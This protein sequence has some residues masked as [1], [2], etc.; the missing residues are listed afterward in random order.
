MP[1]KSWQKFLKAKSRKLI[2]SFFVF[3]F[4]MS[5]FVGVLH[6]QWDN[7]LHALALTSVS[8][9]SG[10]TTLDTGSNLTSSL[11]GLGTD[12]ASYRWS[13]GGSPISI[14][15]APF[16][17]GVTQ[18]DIT[19]NSN[20]LTSG[21]VTVQTSGCQVGS[22]VEFNGT[23]D[24][25]SRD[26]PAVIEVPEVTYEAWINYDGITG[27]TSNMIMSA[28]PRGANALALGFQIVLL[29]DGRFATV[30]GDGSGSFKTAISSTTLST[31]TWYHVV[32]TFDGE[33]I[34]AYVNGV[35]DGSTPLSTPI[36]YTDMAPGNYPDPAQLF[37]G[38]YRTNAAG[39]SGFN[40]DL[41]YFDGKIDEAKIYN[42]ALSANQ[43]LQNYN[44]GLA[45]R[46]AFS[47]L[48][49]DE[50]LI[51]EVWN[52]SV[53][54]VTSAGSIGSAVTSGNTATITS[55]TIT[56]QIN[57]GTTTLSTYSDVSS[58][59]SGVGALE[60]A[61]NWTIG[62]TAYNQVYLP[63]IAG[64]AADFSGNSNNGTLN[65]SASVTSS[66]SEGCV[67]GEC[68]SL[69]T[70]SDFVSLPTLVG[71]NY[72]YMS[73]AFWLYPRDIASGGG[74]FEYGDAA[75]GS[76][77]VAMGL[78]GGGTPVIQ[79]R[80]DAVPN[81]ITVTSPD[82]IT[83]DQWH[84]LAFSYDGV[85]RL[86]VNGVEKG[87][88]YDGGGCIV[89]DSPNNSFVVGKYDL[90]V[91]N[92][93]D[94]LID[95]FHLSENKLT[96]AQALRLYNDG[97]AN[98]AGPTQIADDQTLISELW[99]LDIT[100]FDS[101]GSSLSQVNSSNTTTIIDPAVTAALNSGTTTLSS[102]S[103]LPS[104]IV[105]IGTPQAAYSW[106]VGVNR[107]SELNLPFNLGATQN[108]YSGNSNNGTLSN[109]AFYNPPGGVCLVGGCLELDGVDDV[110]TGGTTNFP[111]GA[112]DR[113]ISLWVKSDD[114]ATGNIM[115]FGYGTAV[116]DGMSALV[117]GLNN[118]TDRNF[119]FWGYF[120]DLNSG[121]GVLNNGAW[122]HLA[123]TIID[124][125]VTLYHDGTAI[126][127]QNFPSLN[128][129][130]GSTYY[131]GDF[132]STMGNFDGLIDEVQV[133]DRGFSA[134]QITQIYN[135]GNSNIAGPSQ[136]VD[137][138]TVSAEVWNVDITPFESDGTALSQVNSSNTVTITAPVVTIGLNNSINFLDSASN[139][140]SQVT[141]LG[142]PT[143]AYNWQVD[144]NF[145][146]E[147]S[148]PFNSG[149]TQTDYSGNS[150][151]GTSTNGPV[152]VS[153]GLGVCA[154]GGCLRFDGDDD[155]VD[156]SSTSIL[157]TAAGSISAWVRP[158]NLTTTQQLVVGRST[159]VGTGNTMLI[160]NSGGNASLQMYDGS[161]HY[162]STS[163]TISAGTWYHLVATWGASGMKIYHN[164]VEEG[165]N[166]FTGKSNSSAFTTVI[167]NWKEQVAG[168]Y[169]F[170]GYIDE[171]Q[172]FDIALSQA[173]ITQLYNDGNSGV[174]GPTQIVSAET[175]LTEVWDLDITPFESNG[176][177]L[178]QS[179]SANTVTIVNN[180]APNIPSL[181]DPADTSTVTVLSPTLS[182][183]FSDSGTGLGSTGTTEYRVSSG[184]SADC[185]NNV[186]IVDSGSSASTSSNNEDT[187]RVVGT[188]LTDLTTYN[189][190][191]RNFDQLLYSNSGVYT[192]MGSFTVDVNFVPGGSIRRQ[193]QAVNDQVQT[194][195][196]EAEVILEDQ[197]EEE[198]EDIFPIDEEDST[199]EID[200]VQ[201]EEELIE[202]QPE[203]EE[204]PTEESPIPEQEVDEAP[205]D[206]APPPPLPEPTEQESSQIEDLV[207]ELIQIEDEQSPVSTPSQPTEAP[208]EVGLE[209]RSQ[210]DGRSFT[211]EVEDIVLEESLVVTGLASTDQDR[212]EFSGETSLPN[213]TVTLIFDDS[214]FVVVTSDENGF[215][216]AFVSAQELGVS[217]GQSA[218]VSVE[219]IAVKDNLRSDKVSV[220][221]TEISLT[222]DEE[223][224]ADFDSDLVDSGVIVIAERVQEAIA[225]FIVEEEETIQRSLAVAT[226]VVVASSAPLWGYAP[227]LPTLSYQ[228]FLWIFGVL[229]KRRKEGR[230]YGIAYDSITKQ[231]LALAIVRI[232][233][234]NDGKRKLVTTVVTDKSGRYEALLQSGEYQIE[235]I[236][237]EYSFP[238]SLVSGAIDGEFQ[239]I[240]HG[241]LSM[242]DSSM[243]L[244]D[245]PLDPRNAN[246]NWE[247]ASF[248]KKLVLG[249][250]K[251]GSH[252]ALPLMFIG[253]LSSALLLINNSFAPENWILLFLY[254][255]M[256]L[257]QLNLRQHP[258]KAWGIV[259]DLATGA[260]LPLVNLQ[261]IDPEFGKVVKS[262]LSDYEG[263]F[264]FLPE[265]G[266]YI[267]KASKEGYSQP[268]VV[269]SS[270]EL[271]PIQG[272]L[273]IKKEGDSIAGDIAMKAN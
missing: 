68:V 144:S 16:N 137:E 226:P 217:P 7:I 4:L 38:A 49:S 231:P 258:E 237:P 261:L 143:G 215:W 159:N 109:G 170:D 98:N 9:N 147:L 211:V 30:H 29:S 256:F 75:D 162:A 202:Q 266:N 268:E 70:S 189:W 138:E 116:N 96:A 267:I 205:G 23:T 118:L 47:V 41:Q 244:P 251:L 192:A 161:F 259:Y 77:T 103:D 146:M 110:V 40:P 124:N 60:V 63:F 71:H 37:I 25:L 236:K 222:A 19:V 273:Q 163:S 112:S 52:L 121:A 26:L 243:S 59:L 125:T 33:T 229:R 178:S 269:E 218:V 100:P 242:S 65:G 72:C 89:E 129:S 126:T 107:I 54:P 55:P 152:F 102:F 197:L 122:N 21:S 171:V 167:G 233:S 94:G 210:S 250:Q 114:F 6:H 232:Y 187:T 39:G 194:D 67:V 191:A 190:C 174:A 115:L 193:Q 44:D 148:Y 111:T 78:G 14:F 212:L 257:L 154:V 36:V 219:V 76:F 31:S 131:I 135:D 28:V 165:T 105:N 173:Q 239:S 263:R 32:G 227:Y 1:R 18:Q 158:D 27:G 199:E 85:L 216:Q 246:K 164:G 97:L 166:V 208:S 17:S 5:G 104:T 223:V 249:L 255:G 34:K 238:S 50:T 66:H 169:G 183:N 175:N 64:A 136:I 184:S 181:V 141:G 51:G 254:I 272:E 8:L 234:L 11:V 82:T 58:T 177:P 132:T 186:N 270:G 230:L 248:L 113:T 10:T 46:G 56:A 74:L 99:D 271:N 108:D 185:I 207:N 240:S 145:Y 221:D 151:N 247:F 92:G 140:S 160:V 220:G 57:S 62:G 2:G 224:L 200:V 214:V 83:Q 195:E 22:C 142:T 213:S 12:T 150:V 119:G 241:T 149:I 86:F 123:A 117:V 168:D 155:F 79:I 225:E 201:P 206:L 84:H 228:F 204:S 61:Y 42:R 156:T 13:V 264:A 262:R 179:N 91:D 182:A 101:N 245:L 203:P 127:S 87:A 53:V 80:K 93:I 130:S 134:D 157:D 24:Y 88:M 90:G 106:T 69:S 253:A 15:S 48:H 3:A 95:E 235:V 172:L 180:L 128:T 73:G 260:S 35:L 176:S 120:A 252:L 81:Y 209:T 188:A 139:L 265:P 43:I 45:G 196:N 153:S 198:I 133:F 20:N